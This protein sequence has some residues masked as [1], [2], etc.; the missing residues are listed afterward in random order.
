MLPEIKH[1]GSN[2]KLLIFSLK[3]LRQISCLCKVTNVP[4]PS[5]F[6][7]TGSPTH[8][9]KGQGK[10]VN[11]PC[12]L[13]LVEDL[14]M[15]LVEMKVLSPATALA[16]CFKIRNAQGVQTRWSVVMTD[17]G[18]F[19]TSDIP[20]IHRPQDECGGGSAWACG[21]VDGLLQCNLDAAAKVDI[22]WRAILRRGD[23][24]AA[25]CQEIVG[26][27]SNTTAATLDGCVRGYTGR[28]AYIGNKAMLMTPSALHLSNE[29]AMDRT[30]QTMGE[31]RVL[32]ILRAKNGDLA[33]A[34]GIE[35]VMELG[36]T[37]H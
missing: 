1:L 12:W 28:T 23:L 9:G 14:Y 6:E 31:G 16:T 3:T 32:A 2:L 37:D 33:I 24:S 27:H 18:I 20:T 34:R 11:D 15:R 22:D 21:C 30:I 5:S 17:T 35:L 36:A 29:E 25:L 4:E 7:L 13:R 26:D 19:K 10:P 8:D